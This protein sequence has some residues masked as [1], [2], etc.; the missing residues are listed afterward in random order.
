MGLAAGTNTPPELTHTSGT[1]LSQHRRTEV[2]LTTSRLLPWKL[3][4]LS[5]SFFSSVPTYS[6]FYSYI[7]T[8][9][10]APKNPGH[11][12]TN[13]CSKLHPDFIATYSPYLLSGLKIFLKGHDCLLSQVSIL[14]NHR[15][16]LV[17]EVCCYRARLIE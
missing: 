8:L 3:C 15:T 10:L 16:P 11:P 5:Q 2:P 14:V 9:P 7:T 6:S 13:N 4:P 12:P 1:L 17:S